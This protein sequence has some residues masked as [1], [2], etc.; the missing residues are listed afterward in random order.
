MAVR[1]GHAVVAVAVVLSI[2]AHWQLVEGAGSE[3]YTLPG[4]P[5]WP[6]EEQIQQLRE[7]VQGR[8]S[9]H[10]PAPWD[11]PKSFNYG[12]YG[13]DAYRA[14]VAVAVSGEADVAVSLA[15]ARR[16]RLRVA[17]FSTGHDYKARS[18]VENGLLLDMSQLVGVAVDQ[19]R[20]YVV[21][22]P[23]IL[24]KDLL[25]EVNRATR[26]QRTVVTGYYPSVGL[27]G[28]SSSGGISPLHTVYGMGAGAFCIWSCRSWS[29]GDVV[30]P[31]VRRVHGQLTLSFVIVPFSSVSGD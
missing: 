9:S 15:F 27:C 28:F 21:A 12:I 5:L 16:H 10:D 7:A 31:F 17:V 6:T 22:G 4:D 20:D 29:T 19:E 8:V 23:G 2:C 18:L 25:R 14:A 13:K 1:S 30:F 24:G 11:R 26:G 3:G